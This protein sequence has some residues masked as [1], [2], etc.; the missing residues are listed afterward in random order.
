M[1]SGLFLISLEN[2]I[3]LTHRE[4]GEKIGESQQTIS[5]WL[6]RN[7]VSLEKKYPD[8][9]G[10]IGGVYNELINIKIS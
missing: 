2:Y 5:N 7:D 4:I 6:N 1:F 3:N 9:S 10:L 8:F